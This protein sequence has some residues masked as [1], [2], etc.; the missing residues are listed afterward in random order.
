MA[1]TYCRLLLCFPRFLYCKSEQVLIC[2][3]RCNGQILLGT[4]DR[5]ANRVRLNSDLVKNEAAIQIFSH[6]SRFLEFK[7]YSQNVTK[8][9]SETEKKNDESNLFLLPSFRINYNL[10]HSYYFVSQNVLYTSLSSTCT[11][12]AISTN[13]LANFRGVQRQ[14]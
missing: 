11:S 13:S 5:E 8:I 4:L 14:S 7:S 9:K 6:W 1:R 2:T 12:N 10:V 3:H